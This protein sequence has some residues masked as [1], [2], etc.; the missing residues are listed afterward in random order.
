MAI[1]HI[2]SI[3]GSAR[4]AAQ[5]RVADQII[6]EQERRNSETLDVHIAGNS[7]ESMDKDLG[8]SIDQQFSVITISGDESSMHVAAQRS[9]SSV[10]SRISQPHNSIKRPPPLEEITKVSDIES[11]YESALCQKNTLES[12]EQKWLEITENFN[13]VISHLQDS[14][15]EVIIIQVYFLSA[16]NV[17]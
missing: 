6:T 3:R 10:Q 8:Q 1:S 5:Q 9:L 13:D 15:S 11:H 7:T 4:M 12:I 2:A 14:C 16:S 17:Q